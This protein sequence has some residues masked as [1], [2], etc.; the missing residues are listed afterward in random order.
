MAERLRGAR[1]VTVHTLAGAVAER[2]RCHRGAQRLELQQQRLIE[3]R[4]SHRDE[5]LQ[6]V[7]A[8]LRQR[9]P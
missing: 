3:R 9:L 1:Q 4:S 8:P 7:K 6:S 5:V 2:D